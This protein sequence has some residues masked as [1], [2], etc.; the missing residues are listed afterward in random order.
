MG[1]DRKTYYWQATI[2]CDHELH[3]SLQ[4]GIHFAHII[5]VNIALDKLSSRSSPKALWKINAFSI[6]YE[7][8]ST[9]VREYSQNRLLCHPQ[10]WNCT[11]TCFVSAIDVYTQNGDI[12]QWIR[13]SQTSI[14]PMLVASGRY[15][16]GSGL[17]WQWHH[18]ERDGVSNHQP[19]DRLPDRLFRRRSK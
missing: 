18:N 19:H 12:S 15:R 2:L 11:F 10:T 3:P 1:W 8:S 7:I 5:P 13:I 17:S 16:P 9:K 14:C 6:I 4:S